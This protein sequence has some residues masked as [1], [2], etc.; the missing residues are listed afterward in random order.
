MQNVQLIYE[1]QTTAV[2]IFENEGKFTTINGPLVCG[3]HYKQTNV[4]CISM[5]MYI[6]CNRVA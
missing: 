2:S 1:Q 4:L 5:S 3:N 6:E